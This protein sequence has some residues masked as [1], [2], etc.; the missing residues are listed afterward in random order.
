M[1]KLLLAL[2]SDILMDDAVSIMLAKDMK[3]S[4]PDFDLR[5]IPAGGLE[6]IGIIARYSLVVIVD[7]VFDEH[8]TPGEIISFHNF[9]VARTLHLQNP[10]DVDFVTAVRLAKKLGYRLPEKIVV[11]GIRIRQQLVASRVLSSAILE[12]YDRIV[13]Q[14]REIIRQFLK[15]YPGSLAE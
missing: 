1:E 10:H 11:L 7:T 2:G 5:I 3:E 8:A 14:T 9:E 6:T 4:F 15:D 13:G 12:K